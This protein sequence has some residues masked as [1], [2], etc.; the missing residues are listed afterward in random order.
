MLM[1]DKCDCPLG[2][3]WHHQFCSL[4]SKHEK[5]G[6]FDLCLNHVACK[7]F[8]EALELNQKEEFSLVNFI[9]RPSRYV[10]NRYGQ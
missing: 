3:S 2:D 10:I 8:K 1:K 9:K 5:N 4:H 7:N 6:T